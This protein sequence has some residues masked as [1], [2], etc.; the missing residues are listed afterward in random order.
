VNAKKAKDTNMT[1]SELLAFV[2]IECEKNEVTAILSEESHVSVGDNLCNGYFDHSEP[3]LAV[4]TGK[5]EVLW[6]PTLIHEYQHMRQWI[7]NDPSWEALFITDKVEANTL[8]DLWLAGTISLD[9]IQRD[10][11]FNLVIE[12]ERNCEQRSLDFI[13]SNGLDQFIDPVDYAQ[14]A[15][16]YLIFHNVMKK[17][18]MWYKPNLEPY[19]FKEI[20]SKMP[21]DF[22]TLDYST[23]SPEI[24]KLILHHC[25]N[26]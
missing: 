1:K 19:A 5:P 26:L 23:V 17:H 6:M 11:L 14:K 8:I 12:N 7:E 13:K 10:N 24:E 15:N 4:G 21:A 2:K 22:T 20:S 9:E 3:T 25:F 18:R 16:A